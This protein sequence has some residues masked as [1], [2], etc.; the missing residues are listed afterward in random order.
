MEQWWSER[1]SWGSNGLRYE[2]APAVVDNPW[3][4]SLGPLS[5]DIQPEREAVYVYLMESRDAYKI[6]ISRNV[7]QRMKDLN[8][9]SSN[10]VELVALRRGGSNLEARLHRRLADYRLNGEWFRACPDVWA[11]FY[12]EP[13][14][15]DTQAVA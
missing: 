13:E 12:A 11:A 6:G 1:V 5:P 9:G 3:Y 15:E 14:R 4:D 10:R 8:C 7:P 2:P